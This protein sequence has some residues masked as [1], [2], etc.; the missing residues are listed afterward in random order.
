MNDPWLTPKELAALLQL[1][2]PAARK[3]MTSLGYGRLPNGLYRMPADALDRL[4]KD[5]PDRIN[6]RPDQD[7]SSHESSTLRTRRARD[8]RDT[9]PLAPGWWRKESK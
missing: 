9:E 2:V 4:T 1:D 6:Q 3:L 8:Q 5:G 7:Q